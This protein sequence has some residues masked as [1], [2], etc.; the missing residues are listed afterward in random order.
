MTKEVRLR[1]NR[2][3]RVPNVR[4]IDENG[5]Q[6]GIV[7]VQDALLMAAQV[8]LD[9][10][11]VVPNSSPP[12][13]KIIDYG[14]FRYDQT[15]RDKESKKSHQIKVKEIKLKPNIDQHDFETK[16]RHA[17]NFISKGNKVK[18]SCFF[19]GRE[20][21]HPERGEAVVKK[22]CQELEDVTVLESPAKIMGRAMILV[23]APSGKKK[24]SE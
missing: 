11:E 18:V 23:L 8:N 21:A 12:V 10:V 7:S 13:C 5:K 15:K 19:R 14:K 1:I 9:L 6:V 17:R 3:I 22:M 16:V 2:Q 24:S 20:L 4:L